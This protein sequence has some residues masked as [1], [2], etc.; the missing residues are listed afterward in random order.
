[1]WFSWKQKSQN[2]STLAEVGSWMSCDMHLR[3]RLVLHWSLSAS[4]NHECIW[5]IGSCCTDR[6]LRQPMPLRYRLVLHWSLSASANAFEI[7]ARA[8]LIAVCVSQCLW[9]IGS[10]CTDRCL[11]QPMPLRY[12]LVL[13]WSLSASANA[14]EISTRAALIAVYVSQCLWH[15]GSC[16]TDRCLRQPMHL[17]YRLVLHWSLSAS[18]NAFEISARAALIAVCVSQC[19]WDIGS[20]CTDRCLCQP[21][22]LRYRLVLHWSLS[23]SANAFEISARAAL[24]AV[25]VSQ[26]LCSS[27]LKHWCWFLIVKTRKV[28]ELTKLG[29]PLPHA[30]L[31]LPGLVVI[32]ATIML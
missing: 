5:D 1:M 17:R 24:I 6:C 25:C 8:A 7:S 32:V 9:D 18:A 14:F 23:A 22:P 2:L 16:C 30:K 31:S 27:K 15:I 3:Y 28:A 26:C 12:R 11:R 13:H 10:C 21:M 20:C 19:L 4:A 29:E